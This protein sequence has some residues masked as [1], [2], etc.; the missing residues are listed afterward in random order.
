MLEH[1]WRDVRYGV[2]VLWRA[3]GFTITTVLVLALAMGANS[4]V[5]SVIEGV[6]LRPL[7]YRDSERLCVL[8]KSAPK[9]DIE[10]DWT[11]YPTTRDW[12]EQSDAF[13]D[14]A[15]V[16]RPEASTVTLQSQ[17]GRE[18]IQGS[19]VS[20]NFFETLGV[21]PLL[22]RGFSSD[23]EQPGDDNVV[24][25][26]H[27]FWQQ[28]FGGSTAVLG[29]TLQ[30]DDRTST[31]I[32]VMPSSFQFPDKEVKLWL[33]LTSDSRWSQYQRV[34]IADAFCAVG[35]LKP[36]RSVEEAR[37]EMRA[38]S[39][40]LAERYPVTDAD[41]GVSVVPLFDQIAGP[42][43]R[44]ALWTL[45]AAVFFVLLIASSNIASLLVARGT[46]RRR[47]LAVRAALGAG[48]GRLFSQLAA[49][50]VLLSLAG[51]VGG[52][53]LAHAGLDAL[54]AL[55]PADLPRS[56]AVGINGGVLAFHFGLCLLIGI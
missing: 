5:F 46:G 50:T 44:R 49:E 25:L 51:G 10:R 16:L 2:R 29:R 30:L 19:K 31:V 39:A 56:G 41:L 28:W 53:L 8:W 1:L 40:R 54:L 14:L 15:V 35:R 48:R 6:L 12:R 11:S 13:E 18:K 7:P 34:R 3:P 32:G 26:S 45:G 42:G 17:T 23:D 20:A 9:T 24:V 47:E 55:A 4:A 52:V 22:G 33:P 37:A 21:R 27:G 36:G 38:I 43:V